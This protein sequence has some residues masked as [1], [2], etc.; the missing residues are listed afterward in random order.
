MHAEKYGPSFA[1]NGFT[2]K[3]NRHQGADG[4]HKKKHPH[5]ARNP[6]HKAFHK[7]NED[8]K[9]ECDRKRHAETEINRARAEK[10]ATH[11]RRVH[12]RRG[13]GEPPHG[14]ESPCFRHAPAAYTHDFEARRKVAE[15]CN[16]CQNPTRCYLRHTK[17]FPIAVRASRQSTARSSRCRTIRRS[18]HGTQKV[19]RNAA[20][21]RRF[22]V[23]ARSA[24]CRRRP[25]V[26]PILVRN[27]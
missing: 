18:A 11:R 17:S 16:D 4:R 26:T 1:R 22:P 14:F 10:V 7:G 19:P 23:F 3:D 9:Q 6:P 12:E 25:F 13:K 27:R 2:R 20:Q 21:K 5:Q 24:F 8:R 15:R